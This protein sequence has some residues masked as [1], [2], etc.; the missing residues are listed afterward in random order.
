MGVA[1]A[2]SKWATLF[3][4]VIAADRR[5]S[6]IGRLFIWRRLILGEF[7]WYSVVFFG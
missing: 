5:A 2:D 1:I 4:G 7:E 6:V 3:A